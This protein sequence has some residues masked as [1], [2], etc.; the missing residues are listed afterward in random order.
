MMKYL[1]L[2][3]LFAVCFSFIN[4]TLYSL[5]ELQEL[6]AQSDIAIFYSLVDVEVQ[7]EDHYLGLLFDYLVYFI[8][9][10]NIKD[11]FSIIETYNYV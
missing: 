9:N 8:F 3:V 4:N 10:I 5:D 6:T 11:V 7:T 2:I 1:V